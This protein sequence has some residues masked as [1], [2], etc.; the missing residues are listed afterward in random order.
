M[1]AVFFSMATPALMASSWSRILVAHEG[2][3]LVGDAR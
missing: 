1:L 3:A 2:D